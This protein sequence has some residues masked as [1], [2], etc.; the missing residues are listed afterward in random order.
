VTTT[1]IHAGSTIETA[2]S[3]SRWPYAFSRRISLQDDA[4]VLAEYTLVNEGSQAMPLL[5]SMHPVLALEPGSVLEL[6]GVD[7]VH[8]TW[9]NRLGLPEGETSWPL[10]GP[11]GASQRDLSRVVEH[12]GWAAKLYAQ[13]PRSVRARAAAGGSLEFDWDRDFAP[14]LGVWLSYGG[15]PPEGHPAEQVALEPTTSPD[16]HLEA[17]LEHG[18]AVTLEPGQTGRWWVTIGLAA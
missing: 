12:E 15:W 7:A 5:W 9:T 11:S 3:G 4:T 1:T 6:P 10:A 18:R 2:W 13:A 16:D 17:A 14:A 8:T